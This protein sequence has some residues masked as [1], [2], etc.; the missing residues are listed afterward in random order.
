MT[1]QKSPDHAIRHRRTDCGATGSSVGRETRWPCRRRAN[2]RRVR[3]RPRDGGVRRVSPAGGRQQEQLR[4]WIAA[5]EQQPELVGPP[6]VVDPSPPYPWT[7]KKGTNCSAC[8]FDGDPEAREP[9]AGA[10]QK[11]HR[12][13]LALVRQHLRMGD[14]R[15][16]VEAHV[17][18]FPA[19]ALAKAP[20]PLVHRAPAHPI[21]DA[22]SDTGRF[23]SSTRDTNSARLFG[24]VLVFRQVQKMR[25]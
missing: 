14:P 16:V 11:G 20:D 4:I 24:H 13:M 10:A 25:V 1:F 5:G 7:L 19:G 23:S 21:A 18:V 2:A 6:F 3:S 9:S 15:V 8:R 17:D 22:T 12:S